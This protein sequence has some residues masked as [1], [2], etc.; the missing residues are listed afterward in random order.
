[1]FKVLYF[2]F[3]VLFPF[4]LFSSGQPQISHL[5]LV[6]I[7]GLII[8]SMFKEFFNVI[9]ENLIFL[10]F[11]IYIVFVN[12][13]WLII[14]Y[15]TSFIVNTLFYIFN[16][17]LLYSTYLLYLKKEIDAELIRNAIL[18]SLIVQFIFLLQS[19][20]DFSVRQMLFFNNPNQL[21][22]FAVASLNIY[23]ILGVN[24]TKRDKI[25]IIKNILVYFISFMLLV[26]SSSKASL[27]SYFLIISYI[28]Y[29]EFVKNLNLSKLLMASLVVTVILALISANMDTIDK[30]VE[31]TELFNRTVN[32]GQE[33]DDSLA[34]RGYDRITLYSQYIFLG[35]GEGY[36]DR[37]I[38]SHHH[39]EL[40]STL[41]NILFS[42]GVI[43]FF[44]FVAFFLN[45][46]FNILKVLFFMSPILLYGLT[47][48]GIRSPLFW[49]A[50]AL[51]LIYSKKENRCISYQK[52]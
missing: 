43:G 28:L 39:G 40:H 46:K 23:F 24:E 34:G 38:L 45:L 31:H 51:S 32:A 52:N 21:G 29:I 41:A 49:I 50:L 19:G 11:L 9:N 13:V 17:L 8:L 35:A 37:F 20:L 47:H 26:F 7:Y 36:F 16:I 3:F 30:I 2:L 22:Y 48:N 15:K 42:Y 27:A 33:S 14:T 1:M 44:I 6:A 4:Y 18:V 12:T 25:E 5:I 10:I